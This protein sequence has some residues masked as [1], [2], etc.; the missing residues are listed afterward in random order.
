MF[1]FIRNGSGN[2]QNGSVLLTSG[3]TTTVDGSTSPSAKVKDNHR[4][5]NRRRYGYQLTH[6]CHNVI[7][8]CSFACDAQYSL[9]F[10]SVD[11]IR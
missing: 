8:I 3:V 1:V 7:R 10:N 11:S 6:P 5:S 4:V 2:G 9:N